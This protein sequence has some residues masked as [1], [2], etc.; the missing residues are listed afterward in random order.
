MKE[1]IQEQLALTLA[2][3]SA[4]VYG[5]VLSPAEMATLIDDLFATATPSFTP[6]GRTVLATLREEEIEKLFNKA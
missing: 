6:D 1:E 5:Q 3:A 2:R 4:V